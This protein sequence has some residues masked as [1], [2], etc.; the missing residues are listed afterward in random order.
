[1]AAVWKMAEVRWVGEEEVMGVTCCYC[2]I[3]TWT[4]RRLGA[5]GMMGRLRLTSAVVL[6][7]GDQG[8]R[9][10]MT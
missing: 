2:S 8:P 10:Q 4:G 7:P 9:A 1:M 3:A 5:R 6:R